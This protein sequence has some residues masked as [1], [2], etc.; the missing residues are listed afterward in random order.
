M[1]RKRRRQS[2]QNALDV[3][4]ANSERLN[5]L[6][7][8]YEQARDDERHFASQQGQAFALALTVLSLIGVV[9]FAT[10]NFRFNQIVRAATPMAGLAVL[11]FIQGMGSLAVLRS[12]YVRALER[13]IR[14]HIDAR[15][16]SGYP[17]QLPLI[18]GELQV[19]KTG[20]AGR[21]FAPF[22]GFHRLLA[23]V[24]LTAA[25]AAFGGVVIVLSLTV[26]PTL[27]L[28]MYLIYGV[29]GA[30]A[31]VEFFYV[32]LRGRSMYADYVRKAQDR[33]GS[34]LLPAEDNE[35]STHGHPTS[36][37]AAHDPANVR[38]PKVIKDRSAL[39]YLTIP[40][41]DDLLKI[42]YTVLGLLAG[43]GSTANWAALTLADWATLALVVL[44]VE[45]L[46]YQARYQWNDVRGRG[47]D[48][49]APSRE[50]RGRLPEGLAHVSMFVAVV[51]IYTAFA[52]A[53]LT[54]E[55][56]SSDD[57]SRTDIRTVLD[58]TVV[59]ELLPNVGWW[60][61]GIF[62]LAVAY[63]TWRGVLRRRG[64][65]ST[66][67]LTLLL[68]L[69]SLGYP[70]R[71][72]IGWWSAGAYIDST[73]WLY[74]VFTFGLGI[75]TVSLPWT[76]EAMTYCRIEVEKRAHRDVQVVTGVD[77]AIRTKPHLL[78]L[79]QV[80]GIASRNPAT[81]LNPNGR[82]I[83]TIAAAMPRTVAPWMFGVHVSTAAA[84]WLALPPIAA[85]AGTLALGW[86]LLPR[87]GSRHRTTLF[88]TGISASL[89][90]I[91]VSVVLTQTSATWSIAFYA[92]LALVP[93]GF[94]WAL[95]HKTY[96]STRKAIPNAFRDAR[97]A[98][99]AAYRFMI[100]EPTSHR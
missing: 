70:L 28:L 52:L 79:L 89:F 5:A 4:H 42:F 12:F 94:D 18:W 6:L 92:A 100:A 60:T 20:L 19:A 7:V 71:F 81:S 53:F 16:L 35:G 83:A 72:G 23:G 55:I 3:Q 73:F 14:S 82:G 87:D 77:P 85:A 17:G 10:D 9:A 54:S 99:V 48:L 98:L 78:R 46:L 11:A 80:T 74:I 59:R 37:S 56:T 25:W 29:A 67:Q 57:P 36:G 22:S 43:I 84:L 65:C 26:H 58:L 40:R 75:A 8:D 44:I 66:P 91:A 24:L 95:V 30:G 39:S 31:T 86:A 64:A 47:E 97:L 49:S 15:E 96:D 63:E 34:T 27:Q 38:R 32:N 45:L 93:A 41:P 68:C 1:T 61:G 76:M 62:G 2:A 88:A 13:E 50:E 69:V 51:R 33:A 90:V 21:R